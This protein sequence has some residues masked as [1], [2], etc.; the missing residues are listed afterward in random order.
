MTHQPVE[1]EPAGER[2]RPDQDDPALIEQRELAGQ[3]G[4]DV[5]HRHI[6]LCCDQTKPK[7]SDHARSL[8]AWDYLKKRLKQLN[9]AERGHRDEQGRLLAIN[10]TKANCLRICQD[11][12][13]A[14][15]YPEGAWYRRC[16]P[17]VLEKI[18]QQHL[19]DGQPVVEHLITTHPLPGEP[20]TDD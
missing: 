7:C 20:T 16:D 4:F 13:I 10:R 1:S 12:P 18:I 11:G 9:L 2:D 3:M 14:V 8:A 15:V 19:I 17:E 6:F 5:A